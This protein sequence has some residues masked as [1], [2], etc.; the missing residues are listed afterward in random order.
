M[1]ENDQDEAVNK[2]EEEEEMDQNDD[3]GEPSRRRNRSVDGENGNEENGNAGNGTAGDGRTAEELLQ[4]L[5]DKNLMDNIEEKVFEQ[6][7]QLSEEGQIKCLENYEK[8][9]TNP[10]E[11]IRNESRFFAGI[12]RRVE[13]DE[14]KDKTLDDLPEATRSALESIMTDKLTKENL[15]ERIVAVLF[16]L[17]EEVQLESVEKFKQTDIATI[18]HPERFYFGIVKRLRSNADKGHG[19]IS[20]EVKKALE[21]G[22]RDGKIKDGDID[23]RCLLALAEFDKSV[24]LKIVESFLSSDLSNVRNMGGFFYGVIKR[25]RR[26]DGGG[27]G[28]RGRGRGGRRDDR[29]GYRDRGYGRDRYDR[30]GY[31]DDRYDRGYGRDDRGYDRGYGRDDR[32]YGRDDR[33]YGRDDR[34]YGRDDRGYGRDDRDYYRDDDYRRG[35]GDWRGGP[36]PRDDYSRGGDRGAPPY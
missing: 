32:G 31:R 18:Q 3:D 22:V 27:G 36:P 16:R 12:I 6:L 28:G 14:V 33:G 9:A 15:E 7:K 29:G 25:Y 19:P 23:E 24:G 1:S 20:E 5:K 2:G 13:L 21:D 11:T 30:G 4:E 26:S 34:G 17:P 35:G 8:S 10:D